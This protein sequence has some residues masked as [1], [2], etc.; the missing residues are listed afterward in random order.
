MKSRIFLSDRIE[1]IEKVLITL[2]LIPRDC[3]YCSEEQLIKFVKSLDI[4]KF[5][6][7]LLKD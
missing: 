7:E 1:K 5:Q 4:D 6:D 2:D 3:N